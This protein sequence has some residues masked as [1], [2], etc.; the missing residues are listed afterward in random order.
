M[1][2]TAS[3]VGTLAVLCGVW[4]IGA[5]PESAAAQCYGGGYS[6]GG[7]GGGWHVYV[8]AGHG[9]TV[10]AGYSRPVRTVY[11]ERPVYVRSAPVTRR[12]YRSS[13]YRP[14]GRSVRYYSSPCRS[15]RV[16]HHSRP[17]YSAWRHSRPAC[18]SHRSSFGFRYR[19][20]HRDHHRHGHR[21]HRSGHRRHGSRRCGWR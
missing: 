20:G 8:E 14:S 2:K 11:V 16:V 5:A 13:Y 3:G 17:V 15:R 4:A 12:V 9:V 19:D 6:V 10:S 21:Y 7:G 18:R 1:F